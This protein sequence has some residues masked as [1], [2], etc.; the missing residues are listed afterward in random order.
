MHEQGGDVT[1]ADL[2]RYGVRMP[3]VVHLLPK[4][5]MDVTDRPSASAR[6]N[7]DKKPQDGQNTGQ[8]NGQSNGQTGG[9]TGGH[10]SGQ[11]TSN[12]EQ[13]VRLSSRDG[14]GQSNGQNT[15]GNLDL[16]SDSDYEQ[17]K[18]VGDV[19]SNV[20]GSVEAPVYVDESAK[21]RDLETIRVEG[22]NVGNGAR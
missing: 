7:K 22:V 1:S 13:N 21:R 20:T 15:D 3:T 16:V 4:K 19:T 5:R 6:W 10:K 8:S 18:D 12:G 17:K 2:D 14:H 11:K 9:Q